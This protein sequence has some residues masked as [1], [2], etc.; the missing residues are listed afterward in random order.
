MSARNSSIGDLKIN[1]AL[2]MYCIKGPA[3]QSHK[4]LFVLKK[5]F[6]LTI[7]M[8]DNLLAFKDLKTEYKIHN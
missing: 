5:H 4:M 8:P 1:S 3:K 2:R 7:G 6:K